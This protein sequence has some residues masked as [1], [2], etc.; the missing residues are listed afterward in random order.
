MRT[1]PG[2]GSAFS[3]T[4][5][6][7]GGGRSPPGEAPAPGTIDESPEQAHTANE[8]A[9]P[10]RPTNVSGKRALTRKATGYIPTP[11]PTCSKRNRRLR[12]I[13]AH[14]L[15]TFGA[16][17]STQPLVHWKLLDD[18]DHTLSD[19][20]D[21]LCLDA[22]NTVVFLDHARLARACLQGGFETSAVELA[23][24]EGLAK[25]ALEGGEAV[26]IGWKV[27]Q[28]PGSRSWGALVGT[29]LTRA[30][31]PTGR[32]PDLL[33]ALWSLHRA[34][35]FWSVVP[36]GLEECLRDLRT[37]GVPVAVVSNS[38]GTLELL[39][40]DL[41][42]LRSF[43]VVIDSGVVGIEKPDPRIFGI[44]L[45]RFAVSAARALHLGDTFASD[46]VGARAAGLR[47][48]LIDPHG[49]YA[50]RHATVPR[51]PGV[52]AVARAIVR[53]RG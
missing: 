44:A 23:R 19:N 31:L 47:C 22:G 3:A 50:G 6:N 45:A 28:V 17:P 7:T 53:A 48:A 36:D 33:D 5:K 34:R 18:I 10:I 43:D 27:E 32:L 41:G 9:V 21:L 4:G 12:K 2:G 24:A 52:A 37:T 30:G 51:V 35:N 49:H 40:A 15:R 46:V 38:E 11:G 39:L 16:W 14:Q 42:I 13:E 25:I 8:A 1:Y 29:M 26:D 20:V